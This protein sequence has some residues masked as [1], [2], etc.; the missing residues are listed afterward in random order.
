MTMRFGR[1]CT[2][3]LHAG[4]ARVYKWTTITNSKIPIHI[5]REIPTGSKIPTHISREIP[6]GSKIP[7]HISREIPTNSKI[8]THISREILTGSLIHIPA[9]TEDIMITAAARSH[10][11]HPI[12]FSS[13]SFL[14]YRPNMTGWQRLRQGA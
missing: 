1:T 13:L 11:R 4:K 6:I 3:R 12:F 14:L 5:S 9:A 7:T 8:P 2:G 10:R